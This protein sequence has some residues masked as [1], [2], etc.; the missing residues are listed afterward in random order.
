MSQRPSLNAPPA[1]PGR[2]RLRKAAGISAAGL[3]AAA[4]ALGLTHVPAGAA[5]VGVVEPGTLQSIVDPNKENL[6]NRSGRLAP[7]A[8]AQD[9]VRALGATRVEWNQFGTPASLIKHGGYLA[10]G[11]GRNPVKAAKSFIASNRALFSL[12]T[13][14][15]ENLEVVNDS[16]LSGGRGHAVLFRQTFGDL[17]AGQ[18]GLITVGVVDGNVAYVSSSAAGD[19][20]APAEPDLTAIEAW[21]AAANSLGLSKTAEA[22]SSEEEVDGWTTFEVDGLGEVQRS[23]LVAVPTPGDGVRPA[24]ETIVYHPTGGNEFAYTVFVDAVTGEVL[25]RTNRLEHLA[26]APMAPTAGEFTGTYTPQE[27]GPLHPI[28]VD[29]DT[30][31]IYVFAT[32]VNP[33]NDIVVNILRNGEVVGGPGDSGTSPE[34]SAY[35]GVA[36]DPAGTE[37]A[38][39]VCPFDAGSQVAPPYAYAGSFVTSNVASSGVPFPPS[40]KYFLNNPPLNGNDTDTRIVGCFTRADGQTRPQGTLPAG[41]EREEG[42]I[43][44]RLPWD[45]D[46]MTGQP[47]FTTTGNAARSVEA[48]LSPLAPPVGDNFSPVAPDRE[49]VFP[50]TD[51]WKN[52]KCSPEVFATPERNDIDAS[53]TSLFG[54]HNRMHDWS[55]FLGFTENN[56]N[57]QV[58]NFG[59][60]ADGQ[61]PGL[62][63]K[64]PEL[65]GAQAG[66]VDGGFPSFMG[67][68]NANQITLNDGVPGITNM[69][70]W[71]PLPAAFYA[72]CSD[73]DYDMS[74]I[75]H[76][77]T[78]A[79]SNRMVGGPDAG[80]TSGSDGQA[81]AMG[82]SYS[83]L[84][85]VEYLNEFGYVPTADEN[86][87]AVGPYVTG[88]DERG[89]RNYGMN[90][91]PLNFS[92]VQGYDGS[93]VGSPH[94]DGEIW[95]AVNFQIRQAMIRKYNGTF[96]AGNDRLQIRCA[97]GILPADRCPGNRRWMQTVFDA[98]LL[99]PPA[100]SMLGSRDAY[101][102][103]DLMRY[104]G[105]RP[106]PDNQKVLWDEFAKRGFGA[107]AKSNGTDDSQPKPSFESPT[108]GN[109]ATV[110]WRFVDENDKPLKNVQVFVGDYE[111]RVTP[112]ADTDP[113]TP[114][115]AVSKFL[116]GRYDFVVQAPGRGLTRLTRTFDPNREHRAQYLLVKNLASV[117]NGATVAGGD[118][119]NFESLIDDTEATNYVSGR[120]GGPLA[121]T[122]T[123]ATP[124]VVRGRQV[125]VD[126][127]GTRPKVDVVKVS[128]LLRSN[129][130]DACQAP[131]ECDPQD[132][133]QNR[134]SALRQFAVEV[135]T[136][137]AG[138]DSC[139]NR[140]TAGK[141]GDG[142]ERIFTSA[143]N[144]FPGD[145]PRPLAPQLIFREFDVPDRRATHVRM[146]VLSNQ[147]T[148]NPTYH[149]DQD[150]DPLVN[151]D[152]RRQATDFPFD[153][154]AADEAILAPQDD[155]VRAAE[156]QV[157]GAGGN[158]GGGSGTIRDPFVAFTKTGP[159]TA[160]QGETIT[161]ELDYTNLGPAPSEQVK[162]TDQL[163]AG[164]TFVSATGPDSYNS[165]T[166]TVTWDI[167]KVPVLADGT[168]RVTVRVKQGVE[169]GTVLTNTAEFTAPLTIATPA[170]M[171]TLVL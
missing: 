83:D 141:A 60:D 90:V 8:A 134:F 125:T 43:A 92:D 38:A 120:P 95:S 1:P 89:I 67:R 80:L 170:A 161:Y 14:G 107:K 114:L 24:Y 31:S 139:G 128:A 149:G 76:E 21:Q 148:G 155:T 154:E 94:D 82:E 42:N 103:A 52:S 108:S 101:L 11:L 130:E 105:K 144:A 87:F 5:P 20:T 45:V 33:S 16:V 49:Y 25:L 156:F 36:G 75:G 121:G 58:S 152:C 72:A 4:L 84:T 26:A 151:S 162:I 40:W 65:G 91:S 110:T 66:A 37:Y 119:G 97:N 19:G 126:L 56:Y 131:E 77:Y 32:A 61:V 147:C 129:A 29:D 13:S 7:T 127:A 57:M 158:G 10:T 78:H 86:P 122:T 28:D 27:C 157:F 93:G 150:S 6:D 137:A 166:R 79:I 116:P 54:S 15:L 51:Q 102:A 123:A 69:Y 88:S 163:P 109:E 111:A 35:D 118:G 138:N 48:W 64:D 100:V 160:D 124:E 47:T 171:V 34:V 70:L 23:R 17:R 39:Q 68:D 74:V 106:G 18:D 12:S 164:V 41:C 30:E 62:G 112:I 168:V 9:R 59:N 117:H 167:G 46:P 81:R 53:I 98:Y 145:V 99:M 113:S 50:W 159:A 115:G 44:A 85:A 133:S 71:Q 73:G 3:T 136:A 96:P 169:N 2:P 63:D 142:W 143:P 22:I 165:R 153:P 135:C 140:S 132:L 146:V 104:G 55:Y